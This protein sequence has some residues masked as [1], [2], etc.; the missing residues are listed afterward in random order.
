[1]WGCRKHW[2]RLPEELRAAIWAAYRPGQGIDKNP[3]AEYLRVAE[4]VRAWISHHAQRTPPST[5]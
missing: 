2:Y 3:S 4:A 5:L 1:M